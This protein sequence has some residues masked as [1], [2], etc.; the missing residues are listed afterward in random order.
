MYHMDSLSTVFLLPLRTVTA[1]PLRAQDNSID[2][3]ES[4]KHVFRF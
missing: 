1:M 2:V 4:R 3:A